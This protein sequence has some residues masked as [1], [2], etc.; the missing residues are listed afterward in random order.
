MNK[1]ITTIILASWLTAASG[2]ASFGTLKPEISGKLTELRTDLQAADDAMNKVCPVGEQ[3]DL[4]T[5]VRNSSTVAHDHYELAVLLESTGK[6]AA[7]LLLD[8][9]STLT[10]MW[11]SIKTVFGIKSV[12]R[13]ALVVSAPAVVPSAGGEVVKP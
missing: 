10:T 6:S 7:E 5:I 4:C 13:G 2:C 1:L 11:G 8:I 12:E 9:T 3:S